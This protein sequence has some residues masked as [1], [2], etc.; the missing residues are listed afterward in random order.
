MTAAHGPLLTALCS[1]SKFIT[2]FSV[3]VS[4]GLLT[5]RALLPTVVRTPDGL[6]RMWD[7][8]V[9]A[10][11]CS[12]WHL[13]A[14]RHRSTRHVLPLVGPPV[15]YFAGRE[16]ARVELGGGDPTATWRMLLPPVCAVLAYTGLVLGLAEYLRRRAD[17]SGAS[18]PAAIT[19]EMV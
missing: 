9:L 3:S 18:I 14:R 13:L 16:V 6:P 5:G 15:A 4:A 12:V 8:L 17:R 11:A 1:V 10:L 2:I 7:A 19:V